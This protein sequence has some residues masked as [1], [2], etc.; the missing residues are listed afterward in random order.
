M[1]NVDCPYSDL[2]AYENSG[3]S[4]SILLVKSISLLIYLICIF[5]FFVRVNNKIKN[6]HIAYHSC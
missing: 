5:S 2:I 1:E 4:V 3:I 6:T